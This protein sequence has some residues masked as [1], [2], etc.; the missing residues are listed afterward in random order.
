M[1]VPLA[2]HRK[3]ACVVA[4]THL[5]MDPRARREAEMLLSDGWS[6]DI[7]CLRGLGEPG[8]EYW[9][10]ASVHH[11]PV[12]RHR[13]SGIV[14]YL[15]EYVAF[16]VLAVLYVGWLGLRRRYALVHVHNLPDFLV[17]RLVGY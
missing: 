5:S 4:H 13:G 16:F 9:G 11:L 3:V 10:K 8:S 15:I 14:T 12:R 17:Q 6:L 1:S 7:I 2:N